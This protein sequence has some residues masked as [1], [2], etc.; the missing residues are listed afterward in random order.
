MAQDELAEF[1]SL[2]GSGRSQCWYSVMN[3]PAKERELLDKA[4]SDLTISARAIS[5]WLAARGYEV[6][7]QSIARH[8]RKDCRC[9]NV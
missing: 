2:T 5:L 6:K 7:H 4:M 3:I 8:I 1:R 9:S